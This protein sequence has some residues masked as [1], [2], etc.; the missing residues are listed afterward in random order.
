MPVS[1]FPFYVSL[2]LAEENRHL[3]IKRWLS[4]KT[5]R[6]HTRGLELQLHS[7]LTSALDV[8]KESASIYNLH[9]AVEPRKPMNMRPGKPK[10]RCGSFGG[11]I[12]LSDKKRK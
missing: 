7:F 5:I 12:N 3:T 2:Q 6:S 4:L 11:D 9:A 1:L 10:G 8:N